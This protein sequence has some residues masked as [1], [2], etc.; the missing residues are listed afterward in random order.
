MSGSSALVGSSSKQHLGVHGE[1][2]R[3]GH[4]LLLP[5]RELVR[6]RSRLGG[7]IDLGRELHRLGLGLGARL[8]EHVDRRLDNV[9][10]HVEV[11]KQVELLKHEADFFAHRTAA[12]PRDH[13]RSASGTSTMLAHP[14][15]A[16]LE[17]LEPV[18]AAKQ[19]GL[20]ASR[21]AD[22]RGDL[23]ALDRKR[24]VAQDL[25]RAV[26][27]AKAAHCRSRGRPSETELETPGNEGSG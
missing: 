9:A 12:P 13:A 2:P 19:G 8:P 15:L 21:R 5:A 7:E 11:R 26:P 16:A 4:P 18:D 10:E 22:D 17:R 3:D 27:L 14:D 1:R 6:K 20:A 24:H 25:E 23:A